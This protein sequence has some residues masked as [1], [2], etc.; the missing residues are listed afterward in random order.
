MTKKTNQALS[1]KTGPTIHVV[2][3]ASYL[4]VREAVANVKAQL[5]ANGHSFAQWQKE[6]IE[7]CRWA[8]DSWG[9]KLPKSRDEFEI[10]FASAEDAETA[11]KGLEP[12]IRQ[13]VKVATMMP[14]FGIL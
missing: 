12:E 6:I 11:I 3:V 13:Y 10:R 5:K 7:E 9:L 8:F 2:K 4:G 1:I 14:V